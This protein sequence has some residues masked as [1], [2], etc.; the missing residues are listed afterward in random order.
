MKKIKENFVEVK[1]KL[2]P[3]DQKRVSKL[4]SKAATAR[5]DLVIYVIKKKYDIFQNPLYVWEAIR[6]CINQKKQFPS[7]VLDYLS[8]AG[9]HL[10]GVAQSGTDKGNPQ[11]VRD[12]LKFNLGHGTSPFSSCLTTEKYIEVYLSV[13]KIKEKIKNGKLKK[14]RGQSVNEII[15]FEL[16]VGEQT[17]N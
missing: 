10:L 17:V 7:W 6:F 2:D 15:G 14:M 8:E 13:P 11:T 4:L 16:G 1:L 12:A 3:A 9:N 5:F